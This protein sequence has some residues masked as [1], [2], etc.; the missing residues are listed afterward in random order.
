M[1][2]DF[3]IE[4]DRVAI[5]I[6]TARGETLHGE[7]FLQAYARSRSGPEEP[8][9]VL[10]DDDSFFPLAIGDSDTLLVSK[11]HVLVVDGERPS[12]EFDE[13]PFPAAR[14][15]LIE[16][17]LAG[18]VVRVGQLYL[19]VPVDRPRLLDFLNRAE[20]RFVALHTSDGIS[21]I[22]RRLIERARPLG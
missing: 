14:P 4:K 3:R 21:L 22:N 8:A 16:I 7:M 6:T 5:A 9:D 1:Y 18:G 10:N 13:P 19:D 20:V 11:D 12:F 15:A 17:V 2:N